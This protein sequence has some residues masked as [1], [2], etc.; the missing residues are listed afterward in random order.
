MEVRGER[1]EQEFAAP[2]EGAPP[3]EKEP[4]TKV[5]TP[6]KGTPK[7]GWGGSQIGVLIILAFFSAIVGGLVLAYTLP[8][9]YGSTPAAVFSRP[10]VQSAGGSATTI[11]VE[12]GG[13]TAATAVA[14]K[15]RPSVVNID[16]KTGAQGSTG[17]GMLGGVGSGVIYSQDGYIVTN[18]HVVSGANDIAVTIGM[19]EVPATLVAADPESD[20]AVIKVDKTGLPAAEFGSTENLKVGAIAIA[21][22]SPF[23]FQHSV[24]SGIISALDRNLTIP[25]SQTGASV[26][27]TNLIQTD[28][29]VNPGN[30]GGAL[31]D[32]GGKIIGINTLIV[33][34]SGTSEGVGFA[35]PVETV[36]DVADQ[37]IKDGKASHPFIG[38]IGGTV[39][40]VTTGESGVDKGV[41]I[42]EVVTGGPAARAGLRKGDIIVAVDGKD[43]EDMPDL[44]ATIRDNK[45]GDKIEIT[46]L[47]SGAESKVSLTLVEKPRQ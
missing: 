1:N 17:S 9:I 47:R 4:T 16:I 20:L 35:I 31:S 30:S 41:I 40:D 23:G 42:S 2:E 34:G 19:E 37:L 18:N 13:L 21:I 39:S 12:D 5:V 32:A 8:Y 7:K 25:G 44:I 43:I 38:I 26:T 36:K 22:G 45:V 33:S 28:A 6:E 10:Q 15:L 24:T 3:I 27:L 14:E 46:Y 11:N 29:A